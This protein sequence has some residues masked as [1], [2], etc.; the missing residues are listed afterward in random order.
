M[1]SQNSGHITNYTPFLLNKCERP[2]MR[3]LR[4]VAVDLHLRGCFYI[5]CSF[6]EVRV[7]QSVFSP[8]N[9]RESMSGVSKKNYAS[10]LRY[11]SIAAA[12][13][14]PAAQAVTTRSGPVVASP[15][16]KTPGRDVAPVSSS[17]FIN[18]HL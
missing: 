6:K 8:L 5:S 2:F 18:P 4:S 12:D 3:S 15:P 9:P 13:F 7:L 16:A 17:T 14:R 10:P 1:C 11:L